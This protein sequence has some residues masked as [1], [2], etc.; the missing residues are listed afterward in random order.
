MLGHTIDDLSRLGNIG[1]NAHSNR[2]LQEYYD[3]LLK[4][5]KDAADMVYDA[6]SGAGRFMDGP[7]ALDKGKDVLKAVKKNPAVAKAGMYLDD[8]AAPVAAGL[9]GLADKIPLG[10]GGATASRMAGGLPGKIISKALPVLGTVGAVADV[11]DIVLNDTSAG[12][13]IMDTAAMGIGG[14][15]GGVLG[16]GNPF[17]IAGGASIGKMASDATQFVFGGGKSPQERKL[18]EALALLQ[19]RGVV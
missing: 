7:S 9:M 17:A 14:T 3:I 10:K 2:M 15:I 12:N 6:Y 13:K 19:A 16:L 5:G 11:G 18:E 4:H 8:A 1:S